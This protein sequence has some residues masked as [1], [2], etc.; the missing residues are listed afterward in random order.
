MS[1]YSFEW[2][3]NKNASN[4]TKHGI[5]FD[6]ASTVFDDFMGRIIPDPDHSFGEERFLLLGNS[7]KFA[8]IDR[9]SLRKS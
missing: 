7:A 8:I 5:T 3:A 1:E 2:D 9:M 4:I 6:E